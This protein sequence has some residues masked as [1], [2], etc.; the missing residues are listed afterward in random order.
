M[1]TINDAYINA[2]LADAT[3]A[4]EGGTPNEYTG[5]RLITDLTGRM[6][7]TLATYIG[8]NFTV[9]THIETSDT[10]GSGFDAT[11]WRDKADNIY[12]SI[13]Q[14]GTDHVFSE[15]MISSK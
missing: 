15:Q 3:Y 9:V 4:L 12:V 7:E 11:V 13:E 14:S 10:F 2:L 1:T 5:S 8:N 6:T